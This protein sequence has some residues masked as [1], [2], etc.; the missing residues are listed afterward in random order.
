MSTVE[1]TCVLEEEEEVEVEPAR[2]E[3]C[4]SFCL[5]RTFLRTLRPLFLCHSLYFIPDT[6][7]GDSGTSTRGLLGLAGQSEL[8]KGL[9]R[10]DQSSLALQ[11]DRTGRWKCIELIERHSLKLSL[12]SPGFCNKN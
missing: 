6:M 12:Q 5:S 10:S 11:L 2:S 7:E 9:S 8:D 1:L 4:R 3:V